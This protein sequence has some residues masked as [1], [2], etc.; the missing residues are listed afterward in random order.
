MSNTL[1]EKVADAGH[2]VA[3]AATDAGHKIAEGVEKVVDFV[4]EKT[5]IGLPEEGSDI[6]VSGIKE[7]MFEGADEAKYH[8]V[9]EVGDRPYEIDDDAEAALR[10]LRAFRPIG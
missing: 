5:G 3:N 9:Y 10:D 8:G 1:K 6:G 7:R 4:K 2:T